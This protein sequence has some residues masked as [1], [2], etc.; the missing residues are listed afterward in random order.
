M[1]RGGPFE[2]RLWF[3]TFICS[4]RYALQIRMSGPR[5]PLRIRYRA[6]IGDPRVDGEATEC[7]S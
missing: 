7:D 3:P 5:G 1:W 6:R 4:G 2:L